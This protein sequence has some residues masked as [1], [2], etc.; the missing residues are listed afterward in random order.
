MSARR[1]Y[2]PHYVEPVF[3]Y[4]GKTRFRAR[5]TQLF[6]GKRW[7]LALVGSIQHSPEPELYTL[8][9]EC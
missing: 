6:G 4:V 9:K 5:V 1:V 2:G 8:P 3:F 7:S